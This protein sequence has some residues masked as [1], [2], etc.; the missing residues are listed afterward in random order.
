MRRFLNPWGLAWCGVALALSAVCGYHNLVY[1]RVAAQ[2]GLRQVG[3]YST[4]RHSYA[5]VAKAIARGHWPPTDYCLYEN[6]HATYP[7]TWPVLSSAL[8]GAVTLAAGSV[9][10]AFIFL[11]FLLPVLALLV[12]YR[13]GRAL[14]WMRGLALFWGCVTVLAPAWYQC[15]YPDWLRMDTVFREGLGTPRAWWHLLRC[16]APWLDPRVVAPSAWPWVTRLQA[17]A[18]SNV[19]LLLGIWGCVNA[20]RRPAAVR[21]WL[22]AGGLC[23]LNLYVYYHAGVFLVLLLALTCLAGR[24]LGRVSWPA[25]WAAAGAVLAA[26]LPFLANMAWLATR[27]WFA[28]FEVRLGFEAGHTPRWGLWPDYLGW[29]CLALAA[30]GVARRGARADAAQAPLMLAIPLAMAL[31]LNLQILTGKITHPTRFTLYAFP[32]PAG[33]VVLWLLIAGWHALRTAGR[34]GPTDL[35]RLR[36]C[37]AAAGWLFL[38][39]TAARTAYSSSAIAQSY[40]YLSQPLSHL[41]FDYSRQA[42]DWVQRQGTADFVALALD[43]QINLDLLTLTDAWLFLPYSVG[44]VAPTRELEERFLRGAKLAGVPPAALPD[45]Y[46]RL[47]DF[48]SNY[49][50]YR[51]APDVHLRGVGKALIPSAFLKDLA[52]RY[53]ALPEDTASLLA[54]RRLDAI[55]LSWTATNL[56]GTV[57]YNEEQILARGFTPTWR[58]R[59][60]VVYQRRGSPAVTGP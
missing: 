9:T 56:T 10:R 26:G 41:Q 52:T 14:G 2:T 22:A 58:S 35:V 49:R 42:T 54:G 4:A 27:D 23:A 55:I 44:T 1:Q 5:P 40:Y 60:L 21:P 45:L 36:R 13:I 19:F 12:A 51:Q 47:N 48:L 8:L 43:P 30:W 7:H 34:V 33:L 11:D 32:I 16:W 18:L 3:M 46:R 53:A 25:A 59:D 24:A 29:A 50:F 31:A 38:L 6:R 39:A 37:A 28:D 15:W 20:L 17:P 57:L